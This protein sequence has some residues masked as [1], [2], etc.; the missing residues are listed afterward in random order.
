MLLSICMIVKNEEKYLRSC[1]ESLSPVLKELDSE[2]IIADTGSTDST[3]SIA[4]EFTPN[5]FHFK[6]CDD[7]AAARNSTLER[8]TGEWFMFIDADE[9][10]EDVTDLISFFKT[11]DYRNYDCA[12][13]CIRSYTNKEKNLYS[14][15][16]AFRLL[17]L[18]PNTR[19]EGLVHEKIN[20]LSSPVKILSSV[21]N[22]HGYDFSKDLKLRTSKCNRNKELLFKKLEK[23]PESPSVYLEL[24]D[25]FHLEGSQTEA[26]KY[27][28]RGLELAKKQKFI[29]L[30]YAFYANLAMVYYILSRYKESL[31]TIEEY[32]NFK[33]SKRTLDLHMYAI[34]AISYFS[35]QQYREAIEDFHKY[36]CL[37]EE[38]HTNP[39]RT[40]ETLFYS[41]QYTSPPAFRSLLFIAVDAYNRIEDYENACNLL[42]R[43]PFDYS[44]D[45]EFLIR[46]KLEFDIMAKSGE[47]SRLLFIYR[48]CPE[49]SIKKL[50]ITILEFLYN[51]IESKK[52]LLYTFYINSSDE[53]DLFI[54]FLVIQYMELTNSQDIQR[55]VINCSNKINKWDAVTFELFYY[56]VKYD[57]P[58]SHLVSII[59]SYDLSETI[60]SIQKK[61]E[62]LP[63]VVYNYLI[64]HQPV[65]IQEQLWLGMLCESILPLSVTLQKDEL[66]EVFNVCALN[67]YSYITASYN[68]DIFSDENI[69]LIPR[70]F[71]FGYLAYNALVALESNDFNHFYEYSK[72]MQEAS[73]K[74]K[75]V[76]QLIKNEANDLEFELYAA[77]IKTKIY[78]LINHKQLE[79]A[80]LL[81]NTYEQLN[82]SDDEI[83][84]I[85]RTL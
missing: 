54:E 59:D 34:K 20:T 35:T 15:F 63:P 17:K 6:W 24:F 76:I 1:L 41:L 9:I 67:L 8:A 72:L 78:E 62:D 2:L 14:E 19:F 40:S 82:P 61:Y 43:V 16:N 10:F 52:A 79:E 37:Y 18:Y 13:I 53:N 49:N 22:H 3:I 31:D 44:S 47:F 25:I 27:C 7:F 69:S 68:E 81:L 45:E 42:D 11:K 12:S 5:V 84:S 26:L 65:S 28:R 64:N 73:P 36:M 32:F 30:I 50:Q 46:F 21:V 85:R 4:K 70:S 80:I 51:N 77:T 60:N 83:N 57:V 75:N 29:N 74:L 56:F 58:L 71:R 66:M 23:D 55:K 33:N 39:I 38:Y 48:N